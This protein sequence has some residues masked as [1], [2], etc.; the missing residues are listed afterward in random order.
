M[1]EAFLAIIL[2]WIL[3]LRF[4]LSQSDGE[5]WFPNT[6]T[7]YTYILWWQNTFWEWGKEPF[8]SLSSLLALSIVSKRWIR[9]TRLFLISLS[10]TRNFCY[11]FGLT[12]TF[13]V[14]SLPPKKTTAISSWKFAVSFAIQTKAIKF[15]KFCVTIRMI[16]VWFLRIWSIHSSMNNPKTC[17]LLLKS[18]LLF[19]HDKARP[20]YG[21]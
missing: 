11:L 5:V 9:M 12:S 14:Q 19:S 21:L 2:S 17:S 4:R 1:L 6:N 7:S 10:L 13:A 16:L 15:S 8:F 3:C 20:L 18:S